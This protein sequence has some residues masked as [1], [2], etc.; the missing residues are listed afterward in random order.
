MPLALCLICG[1]ALAKGVKVPLPDPNPQRPVFLQLDAPKSVAA[2]GRSPVASPAAQPAKPAASTS[3]TQGTTAA[4]PNQKPLD[5]LA[6]AV[7]GRPVFDGSGRRSASDRGAPGLNI[8]IMLASIRGFSKSVAEAERFTGASSGSGVEVPTPKP[9][10]E[11]SAPSTKRSKRTA[12]GPVAPGLDIE[13]AIAPIRKYPLSAGDAANLKSS[14]RS[15]YKRRFSNSRAYESK[16]KDP[17]A[18]KLAHWYRLRAGDYEAGVL[19]M[20]SFRKN[21]PHWPNQKLLQ[22]RTEQALFMKSAAPATIKAYFKDSKPITGVGTAALGGAYIETGEKEKGTALVKQAWRNHKLNASFEKLIRKRYGHLLDKTDHKARID[23]LLYADRKALI[24]PARRTAKLVGKAEV[25]KVN[26]R[27]AVIRR[28]KGAGTALDKL[29][30]DAKNE[31]GVVFSRIQ[32]RRRNDKEKEAWEL[33]LEAPKDPGL[34]VDLDEW[35][36]ERRIN[37]RNALNLGYPDV[38]YKIARDHGP[39]SYKHLIDAEFMAGWIALR[40]LNQPETALNHFKALRTAAKGMKDVA[41]AEYWLGRTYSDLKKPTDAATHYRHA[42][43][44]PQAYYGQIA[45]HTIDPDARNFDIPQAPTITQETVDRFMA[46]DAVKALGILRSAG[47]QHMSRL[48]YYQLARSLDEAD[49]VGLLAEA[50]RRLVQIQAS[51]RLSKIALN[52]G[53]AV[54]EYAYPVDVLPSYKRLTDTVD[55][56]LLHALARQ[57]SEFNH[58]AKSPV[59]ARGLMQMMP[60]TARMTARAHKVGYHRGNLTAKPGYNLMLGAAH[61]SD[62]LGE[63]NGSYI[64]TLVAY[65]AGGGRVS[66]WT[67]E[68]GN[69]N[70]HNVDP[71]DWVE[72]I[73]FTETRNY[74]RKIISTMQVYRA[75]LQGEDNALRIVGD[76]HRGKDYGRAATASVQAS[77]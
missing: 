15:S 1:T 62:L 6:A 33:L 22:E 14:I 56:A 51:I 65:N 71:V 11:S 75:R 74:V 48:F 12:S 5:S 19:A 63:Y 37:C 61:L 34:L 7:A 4:A 23:K 35:W 31:I 27:A 76:L 45:L 55:P 73:P 25:K 32:W 46:R 30:K 68:F 52:R 28:R 9:T 38:A 57:E 40:F 3:G 66:K 21:N 8:E 10:R 18:R 59:G 36:I 43:Q 39:V 13:K 2:P 53:L 54:V 17:A 20:V 26:A 67:K 49:E 64:K 44:H 16:I 41:R 70:S 69:V 42:A 77:N 47:L 50:A 58:K 29:P 60:A 72:R 24:A